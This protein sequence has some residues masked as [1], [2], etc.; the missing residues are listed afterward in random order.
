MKVLA[1]DTSTKLGAV[2]FLDS[3][4]G[5][6]AEVNISIG[7]THSQRLLGAIDYV[8]GVVQCPLSNVEVLGV[9][10]GPG[11]FTGL[12]IGISVMQGLALAER[13][14]LIAFS[15]LQALALNYAGCPWLV[16][17]MIDARR[18]EVFAGLYRFNQGML[19]EEL[20]ERAIRTEEIVR[21]AS[22]EKT[23]FLGDGVD[24]YAD[25]IASVMQA[26]FTIAEPP[27]RYPRG[28]NMA[29]LAAQKALNE[30]PKDPA[31]I[32]PAYLRKSNA[33]L[34]R[35]ARESDIEGSK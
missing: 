20:S 24:V 27:L 5:S 22:T 12:R 21:S 4:S 14:G 28:A 30:E 2:G 35:E 11:S 8:L 34:T 9:S 13:K 29:K 31:Q 23:V 6:F 16:C 19:T 17:P 1:V 15:S 7:Q 25:R 32:E 3:D 26:E 18:S 33:E 10:I